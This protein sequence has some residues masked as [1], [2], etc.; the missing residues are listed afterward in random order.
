MALDEQNEHEIDI[1]IRRILLLHSIILARGGIPLIYMGDEVGLL[2][3]TSYLDDPGKAQDSRWLH[4]PK[5][6][7]TK[8][9]RRNDPGS[10]EERLFAGL[11][12]L[13]KVRKSNPVMH[14][15][16]LHQ[17]S[18]TDNEHVLALGRMRHDGNLLL[19]ANFD[20]HPQSVQGDLPA[21]AGIISNVRNLL[22]EHAP[23]NTRDGRINLG[24]YETL[25]L[26][27]E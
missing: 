22:A 17:P 18:W 5:M 26:A 1:A 3:D 14:N 19:L 13:I 8:A 21:H 16:A 9:A 15:F 7:W 2:N 4:R 23:L 6:D 27:G 10:V 25:W 12:K 20:E 11:L 24:P